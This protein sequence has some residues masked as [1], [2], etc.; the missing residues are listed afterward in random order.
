MPD[1]RYTETAWI[2]KLRGYSAVGRRRKIWWESERVK[3]GL[4]LVIDDD[5][6]A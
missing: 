5:D 4:D 6:D 1:S 2:Y 3:M